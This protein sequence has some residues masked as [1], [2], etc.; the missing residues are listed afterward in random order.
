MRTGFDDP[1]HDARS[2]VATPWTTPVANVVDRDA[3]LN[4][5]R[6]LAA[7]RGDSCCLAEGA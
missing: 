7:C 5:L 6:D 3:F 2:P 4:A 1:V